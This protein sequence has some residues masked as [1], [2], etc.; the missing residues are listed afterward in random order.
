[1]S[2]VR[3]VSPTQLSTLVGL[4]LESLPVTLSTLLPVQPLVLE[5]LTPSESLSR[6]RF[7]PRAGGAR[8]VLVEDPDCNDGLEG[9]VAEG[10]TLCL[11]AGPDDLERWPTIQSVQ[12]MALREQFNAF[13]SWAYRTNIQ[14]PK[15][16]EFYIQLVPLAAGETS[17]ITHALRRV[18]DT[19]ELNNESAQDYAFRLAKLE[20]ERR[21]RLRDATVSGRPSLTEPLIELTQ[22]LYPAFQAPE[23]L[24]EAVEYWSVEAND[25]RKPYED[26]IESQRIV[27]ELE[28]ELEIARREHEGRDPVARYEWMQRQPQLAQAVRFINTHLEF[29]KSELTLSRPERE[30]QRQLDYA[31]A[32]I[33]SPSDFTAL[34]WLRDFCIRYVGS[35]NHQHV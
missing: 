35:I 1:M 11:M 31:K 34:V 4:C 27:D 32:M 14:K 6:Q 5:D 9:R 22:R 29:H 24:L 15:D 13:I 30:E 20:R 17:A 28:A 16:E 26:V 33:K 12:G 25:R 3:D 18:M 21:L 2:Q 10:T 8:A 19:T 7:R 23:R